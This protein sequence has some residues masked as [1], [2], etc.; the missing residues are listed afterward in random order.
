MFQRIKR[1]GGGGE[2]FLPEG[3]VVKNAASLHIYANLLSQLID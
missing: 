3:G 2:K 1:I